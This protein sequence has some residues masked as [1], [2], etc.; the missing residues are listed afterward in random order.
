[1]G[2]YTLLYLQWIANKVLLYLF[3]VMWQ[4]GWEQNLGENGYMCMDGWVAV[5]PAWNYHNIVDQLYSNT[6][7]KNSKK[8]KKISVSQYMY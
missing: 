7:E 8:K 3:N 5:L 6:K 2:M 4:P 1:M